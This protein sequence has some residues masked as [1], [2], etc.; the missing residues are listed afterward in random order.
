MARI[1]KTEVSQINGFCLTNQYTDGTSESH[2][3][4]VGDV[5][6]RFKFTE[7]R[8]LFEER[9]RI[10]DVVLYHKRFATM[11]FLT[12]SSCVRNNASVKT[13]SLD[14]SKELHSDLHVIPAKDVLE[15]EESK[16][17]ER[18]TVTPKMKCKLSILLSD[19]TTSSMEME[20]GQ[21]LFNVT[22]QKNGKETTEDY[23]LQ[24]FLFDTSVRRT[25]KPVCG[26]ALINEAGF[27]KK[28]YFEDI[29]VCGETG[30]IVEETADLTEVLEEFFKQEA[31]SG[32]LVLPAKEYT[33]A[34]NLPKD[35]SMFGSKKDVSGLDAS[36]KTDVTDPSETVLA[37][38][39]TLT[40]H[41]NVTIQGITMTKDS[42][43]AINGASSVK[44]KNCRFVDFIPK[45]AKS[46]AFL[47]KFTSGSNPASSNQDGVLL[48]IEN[49]YFGTN[50]K[51]DKNEMYNLLELQAKLADGSY[52]KNCY[53]AKEVCTHNPINLYDVMD[54]ATI[55]IIGNHFECSKNAVRIGFIGDPH[56]TVNIIDNTYD[57]TDTDP[58]WAGI[59]IIQPFGTKTTSYANMTVNLKNNKYLNGECQDWYLYCGSKSTQ[60]TGDLYPKVY[61][62][63]VL[64]EEPVKEETPAPTE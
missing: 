40:D 34:L 31:P 30:T 9:C 51:V 59:L 32:G 35:V 11:K 54:G 22:I 5:V 28:V 36:R 47:D 42:T 38:T 25:P 8:E 20:E 18:V 41:T 26:M 10:A 44:F 55:D 7:N 62:D 12:T 52:I 53:F 1:I 17:V 39:M 60:I 6:D 14:F 45:N 49:C 19:S 27:T 57:E 33:T 24:A 13:V 63:G 29:K 50:K 56:C 15:Y 61:V 21:T 48:Q 37:G 64:Q 3:F 43:V 4:Y 58:G 16:E 2:D 46:Y 23:T